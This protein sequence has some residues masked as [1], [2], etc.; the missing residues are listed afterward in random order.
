VSVE[1]AEYEAFGGVFRCKNRGESLGD[2]ST[3]LK[4]NL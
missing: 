1:R 2:F 3:N 4:I